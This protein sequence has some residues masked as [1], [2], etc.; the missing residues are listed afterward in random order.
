M[1]R[2]LEWGRKEGRRGG[3]GEVGEGRRKNVRFMELGKLKVIKSKDYSTAK[4]L[5]FLREVEGFRPVLNGKALGGQQYTLFTIYF[6]PLSSIPFTLFVIPCLSSL[7]FHQPRRQYGG[8]KLSF[9]GASAPPISP[10]SPFIVSACRQAKKKTERE[11][12]RSQRNSDKKKKGDN[13]CPDWEDRLV[14]SCFAIDTVW[15]N[16]YFYQGHSSLSHF[17]SW[18][19]EMWQ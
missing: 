11:K 3:E 8:P 5:K 17:K 16:S 6:Y 9:R 1:H 10:L 12:S 14:I 7:S 19:G 2:G 4:L 13:R 15:D 18:G